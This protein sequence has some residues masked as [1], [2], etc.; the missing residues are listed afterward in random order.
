MFQVVVELPNIGYFV[1]ATYVGNVADVFPLA[2]NG[3]EMAF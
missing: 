1:A 2:P 3:L